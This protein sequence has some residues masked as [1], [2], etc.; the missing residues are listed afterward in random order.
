MSDDI[1]DI[2]DYEVKDK[3]IIEASEDDDYQSEYNQ[4]EYDDSGS[5]NGFYRSISL[6]NTTLIIVSMVVILLLV[7]FIMTFD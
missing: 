2:D 6:S 1:I 4:R 7:I 3:Q 5:V